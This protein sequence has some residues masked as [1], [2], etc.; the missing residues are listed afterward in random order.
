MTNTARKLHD[1]ELDLRTRRAELEQQLNALVADHDEAALQV[2][3]GNTLAAKKVA[4]LKQQ[5][6]EIREE[7]AILD[8]AGRALGRRKNEEQKSARLKAV[9]QAKAAIPDEAA[10]V[11]E[12]WDKL[13]D[14]IGLVGIVWDEI[15][16][17][18]AKLNTHAAE[19]HPEASGEWGA[20]NKIRPDMLSSLAGALLYSVAGD[21][22]KP[23]QIRFDSAQSRP[24]NAEE[25]RERV[26]YALERLKKRAIH[27]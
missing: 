2:A 16:T 1:V 5:M 4:T 25:I 7:T 13:A 8:A 3:E 17:A 12:G 20:A 27:V 24:A 26:E 6:A 23:E 11:L 10:A 9:E 18:T 14:A 21:S 19:C 15:E 22:I